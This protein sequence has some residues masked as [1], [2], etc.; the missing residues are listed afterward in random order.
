VGKRNLYD[1]GGSPFFLP[2]DAPRFKQ[3]ERLQWVI[4][5]NRIALY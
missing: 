1:L 5:N 3:K 4:V 2:Q